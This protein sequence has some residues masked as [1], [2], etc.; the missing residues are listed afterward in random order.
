MS[1]SLRAVNDKENT[2]IMQILPD[3][4]DVLY[5]SKDIASMIHYHQ[6]G[7]ISHCFY[8]GFWIYFCIGKR[9]VIKFNSPFFF[10]DDEEAGAQNYVQGW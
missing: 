6:T 9:D 5:R 1:G 4:M 10:Q 7:F 8:Y 3:R 2:F